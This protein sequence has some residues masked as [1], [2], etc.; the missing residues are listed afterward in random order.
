MGEWPQWLNLLLA[1]ASG[2]TIGVGACVKWMWSLSDRMLTLENKVGLTSVAEQL[3]MDRHDNVYPMMQAR[4]IEPLEKLEEE[5][6]HQGQNIAILL[7]RDR[8]EKGLADAVNTMHRVV[9]SRS[10]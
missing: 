1:T 5:V 10:K 2:L 8:I 7:D 9:D 6:K 3:R 4:I